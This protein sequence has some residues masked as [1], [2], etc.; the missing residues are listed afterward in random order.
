MDGVFWKKEKTK[1]RLEHF[2][3]ALRINP[4]F[5]YARSGMAEALKARYWL[6]KLF[7]K[8]AFWIGNLTAKYQ[9]AVIIGLYIAF[10]LLN[11]LAQSNEALRPYLTPVIILFALF[12]FSTWIITPVSN[13]FLRLNPFGKYLL[14]KNEIRSSNL[15][16]GSFLVC[17]AGTITYA[18]TRD[19]QVGTCSIFWLC[20][21]DPAQRTVFRF[22]K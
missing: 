14:D 9:W 7:L 5:E 4:G 12:A 17:V 3:E 21:D 16:G 20:H 8:Y 6:Y 11:T 19:I 15:V 22:Q 2:R 1:K 10:R 13:L 18:L